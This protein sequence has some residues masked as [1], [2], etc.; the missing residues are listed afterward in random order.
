MK[1]IN[2]LKNNNSCGYYRI[3]NEFLK[4]FSSKLLISVTTLLNIVLQT[5]KISHVWSIDYFSPIYKRK[6]KVNDP[7][8]YMG[9]TVVSCF[10]E[11][12][13]LV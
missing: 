5:G 6:G 3:L 13:L 11:N 4:T 9:I 8:N 1:C 2:K 10:L 7:D 12:S